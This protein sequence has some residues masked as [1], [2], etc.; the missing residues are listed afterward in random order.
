MCGYSLLDGTA[1]L[2]CSARALT[3]RWSVVK[4]KVS[5]T[6][7]ASSSSAKMTGLSK[8]R[9]AGRVECAATK[10]P[11]LSLPQPVMALMHQSVKVVAVSRGRL[12]SSNRFARARR[13]PSNRVTTICLT[14]FVNPSVHP[15]PPTR[16]CN[17]STHTSSTHSRGTRHS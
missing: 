14:T 4:T 6:L 10:T 3:R 2:V 12:H 7:S 17:V 11:L 1:G 5:R 16:N 8:P 13:T 15:D 9:C